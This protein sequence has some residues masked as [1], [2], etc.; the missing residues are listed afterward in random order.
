MQ[1]LHDNIL[2]KRL[3]NAATTKSGLHIPSN[4]DHSYFKYRVL[5]VGPGRK[6][7][8]TGIPV[9]V[10]V[11]PGDMVVAAKF[12]GSDLIVDGETYYVLNS[13]QILAVLEEDLDA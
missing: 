12:N 10:P 11:N 8:K 9:P 1:M 13:T 4:V 7:K 3:A 2:V 5:A 6:N